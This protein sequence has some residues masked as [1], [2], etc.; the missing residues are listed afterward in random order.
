MLTV[1][2]NKDKVRP[3]NLQPKPAVGKNTDQQARVKKYRKYIAKK[4]SKS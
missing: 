4:F 2:I 3:G 1:H